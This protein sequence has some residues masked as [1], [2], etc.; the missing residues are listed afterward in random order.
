MPVHSTHAHVPNVPLAKHG[1]PLSVGWL[2]SGTTARSSAHEA[3]PGNVI[4]EPKGRLRIQRGVTLRVPLGLSESV[5][6]M[7]KLVIFVK[8]SMADFIRGGGLLQW[9]LQ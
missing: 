7:K 8:K 3:H 2:L 6:V 9:G 4:S 1:A 5:V